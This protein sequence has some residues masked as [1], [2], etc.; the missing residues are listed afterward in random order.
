MFVFP[1]EATC[2]PIILKL[3]ASGLSPFLYDREN[4]LIGI[5]EEKA[6]SSLLFNLHSMQINARESSLARFSPDRY[7]CVR[8]IARFP[9]GISY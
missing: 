6:N 5:D 8:D 1:V 2:L 4:G 9:A 7:T 3:T